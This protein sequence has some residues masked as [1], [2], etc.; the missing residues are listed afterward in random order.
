[1][2]CIKLYCTVLY[3]ILLCCTLLPG[4]LT[5]TGEQ[6]ELGEEGVSGQEVAE[7]VPGTVL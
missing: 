7:V 1:M 6:E 5:V 2:Y 4:E 3:C